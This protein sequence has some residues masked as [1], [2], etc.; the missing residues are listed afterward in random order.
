MKHFSLIEPPPET[1]TAVIVEV[2]HAGLTVDA[3]TLAHCIA[4]SRSIGQDADLLVADLFQEAPSLGAHLLHTHMSRYVCDLNRDENELDGHTS[5]IGTIASAPHGVVWRKT[6]DGRPAIASPLAPSEIE[7]RLALFYRPYHQALYRLVQ[8]KLDR[9]GFVVLLCAH[10][11]PSF[12][13]MGERRAD[14]VPGSRGRT[15]AGRKVISACDSAAA[16]AG[17]DVAHDTPYRGGYT[18][19]RYGSP[20]A[21]VHAL[22][23]ELARRIYMDESLL[24]PIS[25]HFAACTRFCNDLV[26]SLGEL[27]LSP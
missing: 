11:M 23:V 2:P 24:R 20:A 16:R 19:R 21:H 3:E 10:S 18:T 25:G 5:P 7:R 22:Q 26:A 15:T 13:R 8:Q 12:G 9:F 6:T 14:L 17:Y 1:E 4:P 27:D